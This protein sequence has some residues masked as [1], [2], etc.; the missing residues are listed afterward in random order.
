MFFWQKC[1]WRAKVTATTKKSWRKPLLG[2]LR[3]AGMIRKGDVKLG[4][5]GIREALLDAGPDNV[6]YVLLESAPRH[7]EVVSMAREFGLECFS[8]KH[9]GSVIAFASKNEDRIGEISEFLINA[10]IIPLAP[11]SATL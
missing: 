4:R 1:N 5:S 11:L 8:Y 9:M 7:K 2:G 6:L 3:D 10:E